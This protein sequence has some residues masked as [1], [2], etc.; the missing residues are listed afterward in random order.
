MIK[1]SCQGWL[2]IGCRLAAAPFGSKLWLTFA[3]LGVYTKKRNH[4]WSKW[5]ASAQED[6]RSRTIRQ[7]Q[8]RF[9]ALGLGQGSS[10]E[11][12]ARTEGLSFS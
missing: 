3:N 2:L 5:N 4:R 11:I 12:C 1:E 10:G 9:S 7:E 6:D 8:L